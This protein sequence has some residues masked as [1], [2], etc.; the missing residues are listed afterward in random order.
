MALQLRRKTHESIVYIDKDSAPRIMPYRRGF[1]PRGHSD[2]HAGDLSESADQGVAESR[3][4]DP[5][6][7][8]SSARDGAA[9]CA[10]RAGDA[11]DDRDGRHLAAAAADG[12]ARHAADDARDR[13][14][15]VRGER[16]RRRSH[17]HRQFPAPQDDRVG[18][19]A[20]G[21]HGDLRRVL[22]RPLLQPR[23]RGR[24]RAGH[25]RPHA[26][27]RAAAGQQTC[28]R[29]RPAHLSATS[30]S[31]RWTAGTSRSRSGLCDYESL[32]CASRAADDPR[33]A[34][35]HGPA[36]VGAESQGHPAGQDCR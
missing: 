9:L 5:L 7:G 10:A 8:K 34:F 33:F 3:G 36:G 19:E 27:Q 6:C 30:I 32:A 16:R 2:R 23:R 21:R 29:K 4:G 31:S 26:A 13:A 25:D 28:D 35:V 20:D 14:R 24:R 22:P 1:Y 12:D 17:H 11:G 15:H 18:N